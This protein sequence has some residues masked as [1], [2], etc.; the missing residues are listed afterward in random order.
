MWK[1][2]LVWDA[3]LSIRLERRWRQTE[4]SF[5]SINQIEVPIFVGATPTTTFVV[6]GFADASSWRTGVVFTFPW[7]K[8]INVNQ[9]CSLQSQGWLQL[10]NNL[11]LVWSSVLPYCSVKLGKNQTQI[12]SLYLSHPLLV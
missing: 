12:S 9:L 6:H 2:H 4:D 11:Y 5:S 3:P 7:L 1:Q 10:S 8:T